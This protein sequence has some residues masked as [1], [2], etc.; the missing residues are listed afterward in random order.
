M[1]LGRNELSDKLMKDC[2]LGAIESRNA[3]DGVLDVISETLVGGE[4]VVLRGFGKFRVLS[5]PDRMGCNPKTGEPEHIRARSVVAF[6]AFDKLKE[7][8]NG[9]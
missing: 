4:S 7:A 5:K 8:V 6:I 3:V 1:N 9:A 2:G